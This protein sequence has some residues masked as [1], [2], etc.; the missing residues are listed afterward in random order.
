[1]RKKRKKLEVELGADAGR[2]HVTQQLSDLRGHV[3]KELSMSNT[4]QNPPGDAAPYVQLFQKA[5]QK[6]VTHERLDEQITQ[7][8][9]KRQELQDELRNIQAQINEEFD[10]RI[11]I[12]EEAAAQ[13]RPRVTLSEPK[14]NGPTRF[15]AQAIEATG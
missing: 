7:I 11:N 10:Q 5:H 3:K 12:A 9:T 1:M 4:E 2:T 15:A 13:D 8:M 14:R 6:I